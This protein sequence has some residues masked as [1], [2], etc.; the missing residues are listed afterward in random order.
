MF[1]RSLLL[2]MIALSA[3]AAAATSEAERSKF[4]APPLDD[5]LS[6]APRAD[7]SPSSTQRAS[8]DLLRSKAVQTLT[9]QTGSA[10]E[11]WQISSEASASF[12]LQGSHGR[13]FKLFN[14]RL[15]SFSQVILDENGSVLDGP[16]LE[17]RER[18]EHARRFGKLDPV[19]F[20]R[21]NAE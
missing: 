11:D 16:A 7:A 19:L 12:P 20:E 2:S 21:L 3:C 15:R 9:A 14:H 8:A 13:A 4:D 6:D 10:A 17:E 1:S 18:I 5:T